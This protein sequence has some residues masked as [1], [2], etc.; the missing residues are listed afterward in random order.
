MKIV[1]VGAGISGLSFALSLYNEASNGDF[2]VIIL[3]KRP[4]SI[5]STEEDQKR[6]S[7]SLSLRTDVGGIQTT[8]K[9]GLYD[10]LSSLRTNTHGFV[11]G[12]K[13]FG[14]KLTTAI[15]LSTLGGPNDDS[16]RLSRANLW[17]TLEEQSQKQLIEIKWNS[18]VTRV[19]QSDEFAEI[20]YCDGEGNEQSI[21]ADLIVGADGHKSVVRQHITPNDDVKFLQTYSVGLHANYPRHLPGITERHGIYRSKGIGLFVADEGNDKYLL[22]FSRKT[23]EKEETV[24]NR[25]STNE[26]LKNE[27]ILLSANFPEPLPTLVREAPE[28]SFFLIVCR[29]KLP[30]ENPLKRVVF[31]GDAAHA[32]SPF[33]G[34]GA[35]MA[36]VDGHL[37][38][39]KLIKH[40]DN[41]NFAL[42][43]FVAESA[44]LSKRVV[45]E[46]R[47]LI[48]FIHA[49]SAITNLLANSVL[50]YASAFLYHPKKTGITTVGVVGIFA[51]LVTFGM[52]KAKNW[53]K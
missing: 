41:L 18:T 43:E 21:K 5:R 23:T 28:D 24:T 48:Q 50:M 49:S 6:Y 7:Y 34:A 47:K 33:A 30:P 16:I 37:L 44:K 12:Y 38:A 22:G 42:S 32:V 51:A 45:L 36:L 39:S 15:D 25:L 20:F 52:V 17:K 31:I 10:Q 14:N 27:G 9:L 1:V 2:E 53:N 40:K 11:V 8:K 29:D 26:Q 46:Q 35:N 13:G 3:E 4:G 19:T